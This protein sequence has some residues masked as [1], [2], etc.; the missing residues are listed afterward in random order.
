MLGDKV[1]P[2]SLLMPG[3]FEPGIP[4]ICHAFFF[5]QR[6]APT[7]ATLRHFRRA[8]PRVTQAIF[9]A[10]RPDEKSLVRK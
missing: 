3:T 8:L 4:D 7:D 10:S 6:L 9:E 5:L 2:R 1:W